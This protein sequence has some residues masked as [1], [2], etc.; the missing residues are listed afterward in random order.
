M[1]QGEA[2]VH[3]CKRRLT[4]FTSPHV[5]I[6]YGTH[7]SIDIVVVVATADVVVG[8]ADEVVVVVIL[9]KVKRHM[10]KYTNKL[11]RNKSRI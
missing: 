8:G 1:K 2:T 4:P 6:F 9:N 11:H 3:Y 7:E 5:D 10:Y